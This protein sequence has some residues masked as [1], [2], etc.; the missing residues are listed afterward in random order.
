MDTTLHTR[1][2]VSVEVY[3]AKE[4]PDGSLVRDA[5]GNAIPDK[6]VSYKRIHNTTGTSMLN[7]KIYYLAH[8]VTTKPVNRV[9]FLWASGASSAYGT[10]SFTNASYATTWLSSWTNETE[11]DQTVATIRLVNMSDST[12]VIFCSASPAQAVAD[13]EIMRVS[14]THTHATSGSPAF[15]ND[16]LGMLRDCLTGAATTSTPIYSMAFTGNVASSTVVLGTPFSGGTTA[17]TTVVWKPSATATSTNTLLTGYTIY[18]LDVTKTFGTATGLT[19]AWA[20]ATSQ[21]ITATLTVT[22]A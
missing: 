21:S 4:N 10:I 1:T 19:E 2:N 17:D 20:G 9:K 7:Y 22:M 3:K 18:L 6:L 13:H 14:W 8:E 5:D 12:D 15:H 11:S 16:T